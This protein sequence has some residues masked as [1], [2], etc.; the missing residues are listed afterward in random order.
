MAQ[1]SEEYE[2][3]LREWLCNKPVTA[4]P[5]IGPLLGSRLEE[6]GFTTA[7]KVMELFVQYGRDMESFKQWLMCVIGS[8]PYQAEISARALWQWCNIHL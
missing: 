5:G 2:D 3:F 7:E 4:I 8:P 1:T 6:R